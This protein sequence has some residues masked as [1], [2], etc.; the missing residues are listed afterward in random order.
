MIVEHREPVGA[1]P[2]AMRPIAFTISINALQ[3]ALKRT[4][5]GNATGINH[6]YKERASEL[7]STLIALDFSLLNR[8][9]DET[10]S[11]TSEEDERQWNDNDD[12]RRFINRRSFVQ[13]LQTWSALRRRI[14]SFYEVRFYAIFFPKHTRRL[15]TSVK[16]ARTARA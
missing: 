14:R 10:T 2:S 8:A 9:N 4:I 16:H 12:E 1:S 3:F 11:S 15:S 13:R 5:A 6:Y 7:G